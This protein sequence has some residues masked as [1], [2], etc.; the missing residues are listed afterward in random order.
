[1]ARPP[2]SSRA[3]NVA[4]WI[5]PLATGVGLSILAWRTGGSILPLG[6]GELA[7]A[8]LLGA[9]LRSAPVKVGVLL[10][11]PAAVPL[12][13]SEPAG[14]KRNYLLSLA[15]LVVVALLN[16]AALEAGGVTVDELRGLRV[17]KGRQ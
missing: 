17:S 1:M 11:L 10:V 13:L 16:V 4:E 15:I 2:R 5:L 14:S 7:A 12:L 9:L 8:F 6:S 3:T